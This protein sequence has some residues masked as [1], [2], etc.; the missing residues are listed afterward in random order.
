LGLFFIYLFCSIYILL[1]FLYEI[2]ATT[3][4]SHKN[5]ARTST[6]EQRA[7][8]GRDEQGSNSKIKQRNIIQW[9]KTRQCYNVVVSTYM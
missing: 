5:I 1:I 6:Q 4:F 3:L 7:K 9:I 8:D 2:Y